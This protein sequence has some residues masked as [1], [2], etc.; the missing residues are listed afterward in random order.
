MVGRGVAPIAQG[1]HQLRGAPLPPCSTIQIEAGLSEQGS[2]CRIT[3]P[4]RARFDEPAA[5]P[6]LPYFDCA[7][8]SHG[9]RCARENY[10]PVARRERN[11]GSA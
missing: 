5:A 7:E 2:I 3:G 1:Y 4:M 6:R 10:L 9:G 8:A 11:D